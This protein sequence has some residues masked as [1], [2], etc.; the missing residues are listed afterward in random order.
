MS[1]NGRIINDAVRPT[2][3]IMWPDNL[4]LVE[5]GEM[6]T[7]LPFKTWNPTNVL[8]DADKKAQLIEN[9]KNY[10]LA[11]VSDTTGGTQLVFTVS[12]NMYNAIANENIEW[13]GETM[14]LADAFLTKNWLFAGT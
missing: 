12:T 6:Q 11:K 5:V 7:N 10:I 1:S 8:A 14:T 9:I 2:Y 3:N 13:Q 4:I